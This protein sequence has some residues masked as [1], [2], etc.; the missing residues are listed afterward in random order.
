MLADDLADQAVAGVVALLAG[1]LP[2]EPPRVRH[3][4]EDPL[5]AVRHVEAGGAQLP[6]GLPVLVGEAQELADDQERDREGEGRHQVDDTVAGGG[7]LG[8]LVELGL[9]DR[10]D[11]RAQPLEAA[12]RELWGEQ[13]AQPGVL[14]RVGEPET[15]DVTVGGRPALAHE[16][17]DVGA[18][19]RGVGQHLA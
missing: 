13:L 12:H 7:L 11:P 9:D 19:A 10:G 15:A 1:R 3:R 8:D 14:R 4:A 17:P 5:T 6:E 18:V 2:E 16:R